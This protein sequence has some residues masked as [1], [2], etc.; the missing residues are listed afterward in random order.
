MSL[1]SKH[2]DIRS[3]NCHCI[4]NLGLL[5]FLNR[6]RHH[7][8]PSVSLNFFDTSQHSPEN[9]LIQFSTLPTL[10]YRSKDSAAGG[11]S[12]TMLLLSF[13][14]WPLIEI[15]SSCPATASHTHPIPFQLS[16]NF[17]CR[18][19]SGWQRKHYNVRRQ[20]LH[21]TSSNVHSCLPGTVSSRDWGECIFLLA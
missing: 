15:L 3:R 16:S 19:L 11:T 21:T 7:A 4:I 12:V 10:T 6:F 9:I 18:C 17:H 8:S 14:A 1:V 2:Q 13:K 20:F 5:F